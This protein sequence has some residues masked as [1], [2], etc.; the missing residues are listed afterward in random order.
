MVK[1][2][3]PE[4]SLSRVVGRQL[5]WSGR[6][7]SAL[8]RYTD[9]KYRQLLHQFLCGPADFLCSLNSRKRSRTGY[10]MRIAMI[11]TGYVSLA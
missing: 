3:L 9:R 5:R 6:F 2:V 10:F 7:E 4:L 8:S 11:G 1:T